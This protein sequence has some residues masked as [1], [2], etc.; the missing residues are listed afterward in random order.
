VTA[1]TAT[2]SGAIA[3][4]DRARGLDPVTTALGC[5]LG[6]LVLVAI[7][8]PLLAPYPPNQGDILSANLPP[9]GAHWLGTDETG[10]DILSRLLFGARLSLLGPA[11]I[12]LFATI[13]GVAMAIAAVWVGGWFDL[14]AARVLDL[15]FAFPGLLVAILAVAI[16]GPG[17]FAPVVALAL[18]YTPYIARVVRT[19]ALRERNLAYIESCQIVG[20][21][22]WR[23][24]VRHLV[25][26]VFPIVRA[27]VT[28]AFGAALVDLAAVSYLGLGVQP[29]QAEW[30]LMVSNGQSSFLNGFPA[31]SL[32]A[33]AMIILVV[34]TV[35]VMGERMAL[36]AEAAA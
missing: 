2:P 30:G 11:L 16:L 5:A 33:C 3:L 20:L 1:L 10:R 28:I 21:S 25:P 23:I 22:A 7:F 6:L 26:N 17:L 31:E 29:P 9:S 32:S 8:A 36:R 19:V 34:V 14:V 18:A 12:I 15:L 27:Q 13:I 4:R 24:C 35:N